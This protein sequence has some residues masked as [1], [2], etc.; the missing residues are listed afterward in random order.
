MLER[1]ALHHSPISV[2]S[3]PALPEPM[4]GTMNRPVLVEE[5]PAPHYIMVEDSPAPQCIV[6]EK[7]PVP[8]SGV[9]DRPCPVLESPD[10]TADQAGTTSP[11]PM[12]GTKDHPS[13]VNDSPAAPKVNNLCWGGGNP[14][15]GGSATL[16]I[17]LVSP[18]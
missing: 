7:S 4:T 18:P 9:K 1:C 6:A 2:A 11:V 12:S 10:P 15:E 5:S 3:S 14:L 13:L 16:P 8:M 17:N